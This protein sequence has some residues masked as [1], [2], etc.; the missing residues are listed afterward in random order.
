[1]LL[2][3]SF[4]PLLVNLVPYTKKETPL[5]ARFPKYML[6]FCSLDHIKADLTEIAANDIAYHPFHQDFSA[7]RIVAYEIYEFFIN[8]YITYP[9]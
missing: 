2:L 8:E 5:L 3:V 6:L 1:M 4:T 9:S 7:V